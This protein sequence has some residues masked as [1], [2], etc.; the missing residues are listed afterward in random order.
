MGYNITDQLEEYANTTAYWFHRYIQE[1]F[2]IEY[3]YC[4][5][6]QDYLEEIIP[7]FK[8]IL[9]GKD[10]VEDWR[11]REPNWFYRYSGYYLELVEACQRGNVESVNLKWDNPEALV[12][13]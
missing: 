9:S 5:Q 11:G 8:S 6:E 13:R 3:G 12:P 7:V 10:L 2:P 1:E 4:I